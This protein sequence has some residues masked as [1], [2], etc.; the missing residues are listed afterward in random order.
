MLET[1][2]TSFGQRVDVHNFATATLRLHQRS[3]HAWMICAGVLTDDENRVTQIKILERHCALAKTKRFFHPSAAR[4]MT[5]VRAVR[6]IV[7]P[8]LSHEELI[9]KCGLVAGAP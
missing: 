1:I 7:R 2:E 8:K 4:F 5:H 6:K 3:Q 9:K